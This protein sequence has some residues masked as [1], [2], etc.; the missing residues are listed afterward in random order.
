MK[1]D[2]RNNSHCEGLG[3]LRFPQHLYLISV[4]CDFLPLLLRERVEV[5]HVGA[6]QI[7]GRILIPSKKTN[8][9]P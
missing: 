9:I 4:K 3:M 5:L 1:N 6:E 7:L 8:C 2:P